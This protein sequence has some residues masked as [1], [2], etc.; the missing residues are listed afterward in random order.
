MKCLRPWVKFSR[1][2]IV[3]RVEQHD[4][5]LQDDCQCLVPCWPMR[6]MELHLSLRY[7]LPHYQQN[8]TGNTENNIDVSE[9]W[10]VRKQ[11]KPLTGLYWACKCLAYLEATSLSL[12]MGLYQATA[13]SLSPCFPFHSLS[14]SLP[15]PHCHCLHWFPSTLLCRILLMS[16]VSLPSPCLSS[17]L[18]SHDTESRRKTK[19]WGEKSKTHSAKTDSKHTH[20]PSWHPRN[21]SNDLHTVGGSR[22][23]DALDTQ[24]YR[25]VNHTW[26]PWNHR[27]II[28]KV[29]LVAGQRFSH[30]AIKNLTTICT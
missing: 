16:P 7:K 8:S 14:S 18:L 10:T 25:E 21:K 20:T 13:L 26:S 3:P 29:L 30:K 11:P 2:F 28:T 19:S 9:H 23:L 5:S 6:K 1:C 17:R 4:E 22:I 27:I 12:K 24:R 15:W